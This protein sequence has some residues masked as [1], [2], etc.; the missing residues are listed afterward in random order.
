MLDYL[1]DINYTTSRSDRKT[2]SIQMNPDGSF[3]V[4]AP[5]SMSDD[6]IEAFICTKLGW[7]RKTQEKVRTAAKEADNHGVLSFEEVKALADKAL[8]VIP[9]RVNYYAP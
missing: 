5:L 1:K 4:K 2:I 3:V 9:E 6:Q 8:Q 7:I